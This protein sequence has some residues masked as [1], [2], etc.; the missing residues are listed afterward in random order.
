MYEANCFSSP[1]NA[2]RTARTVSFQEVLCEREMLPN[3]P[4]NS[5]FVPIFRPPR[6][7]G[8]GCTTTGSSFHQ[9]TEDEKTS[10]GAKSRSI[11][12]F[13]FSEKRERVSTTRTASRWKE[14]PN[15][16]MMIIRFFSTNPAR[17]RFSKSGATAE[18]TNLS[19]KVRRAFV[20]F[21]KRE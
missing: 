7:R 10:L 20:A 9:T 18:R 4:G 15:D 2:K 21:S 6:R 17:R 12:H 19:V 16:V 5:Y 1:S 13:M 11:S 3:F 8:G 14:K